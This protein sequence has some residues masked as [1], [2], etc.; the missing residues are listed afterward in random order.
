[1]TQS[2]SYAA[3]TPALLARKG[4]ARP[5]QRHAPRPLGVEDIQRLLDEAALAEMPIQPDPVRA[6]AVA[7]AAPDVPLRDRPAAFT[8]RISPERHRRL[9]MACILA[10]RSA[11]TLVTEAIDRL[12][13]AIP[14]L[15]A[16]A[17]ASPANSPLSNPDR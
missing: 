15:D 13:A 12:L 4:G 1:M 6:P 10:D 11:Q 8:L 7:D 3:L 14:G 5:A 9:R 16:L 17:P 2:H